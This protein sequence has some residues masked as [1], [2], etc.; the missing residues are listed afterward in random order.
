[1]LEH[2]FRHIPRV[3]ARLEQKLWETGIHSW[4]HVLKGE[5]PKLPRLNRD[6]L[7]RYAEESTRALQFAD[8]RY[9]ADLL[10]SALHWRFFPEFR[11]RI[12][13]LDIET[14]GIGAGHGITTIA[15]YDGQRVYTFVRGRDLPA[16]AADVFNYDVLVTFNG[17]TFDVPF[18][19]AEFGITLPQVHI[20]LRYVLR[21]LG[22]SGGLKS[23]EHQMGLNRGR[24]DGVDGAMAVALWHEYKRNAR[25]AALETLLAY[26]VQDVLNLEVLL[27]KA[28]NMEVAKTPF[29]AQR[30]LRERKPAPNPLKP[31][32]RILRELQRSN[33]GHF[34]PEHTA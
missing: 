5:V 1:M 18:I 3:S 31:D 19:E 9:F 12:A 11:E 30:K 4:R 32:P 29:A 10:P 6:L 2:T 23:C 21:R 28:Y 17:K 13:Y 14:T 8:V 34:F 7:I 26:N 33:P 22:F 27:V 16:F 24:L 20:D 15:L 25:P